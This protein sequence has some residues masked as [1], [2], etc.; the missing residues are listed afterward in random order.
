MLLIYYWNFFILKALLL[1]LH[2]F[3]FYF[4]S[5]QTGA[6]I[7]YRAPQSVLPPPDNFQFE[8]AIVMKVVSRSSMAMGYSMKLLT[9]SPGRK[10]L[11]LAKKLMTNYLTSEARKSSIFKSTDSFLKKH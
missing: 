1:Y 4:L 8:R 7:N 2:N 3:I 11:S 9:S 6:L 10:I 5:F